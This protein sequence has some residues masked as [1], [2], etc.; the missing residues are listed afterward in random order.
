M[1]FLSTFCA[2]R[3]Y[4]KLKHKVLKLKHRALLFIQWVNAALRCLLYSVAILVI[5]WLVSSRC[6]SSLNSTKSS[7]FTWYSSS[8]SPD[9]FALQSPVAESNTSPQIS[10]WCLLKS[11]PSF[12]Q[13]FSKLDVFIVIKSVIGLRLASRN[14]AEA[15]AVD[16]DRV[17][18]YNPLLI[19]TGSPAVCYTHPCKLRTK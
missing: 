16:P 2:F 9:S 17:A 14:V 4:E 15:S 8:H 11:S 10:S 6:P 7:I 1:Y 5:L 3:N 12:H 19:F 13:L 18:V